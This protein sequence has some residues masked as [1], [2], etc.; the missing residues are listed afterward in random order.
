LLY[1][2]E[3]NPGCETT[4][5]LADFPSEDLGKLFI[6]FDP[7]R[8]IHD[9]RGQGIHVDL[10]FRQSQGNRLI[11]AD[12]T[13]LA[14]TVGQNMRLTSTSRLGCQIDNLAPLTLFDHLLGRCLTGPE[15]SLAVH[16][17]HQVPI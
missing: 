2:S 16:I 1:P 3:R 9:S 10:V 8:R 13:G 7:K 17:E 5:R 14:G 15:Q 4:L 11:H 12:H 6:Y